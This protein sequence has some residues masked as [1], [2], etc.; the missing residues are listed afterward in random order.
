MGGVAFILLKVGRVGPESSKQ[1]EIRLANLRTILHTP[2]NP[3]RQGETDVRDGCPD[4]DFRWIW[5]ICQNLSF[6]IQVTV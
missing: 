5:L 4:R 6:I 2:F 1:A 3:S